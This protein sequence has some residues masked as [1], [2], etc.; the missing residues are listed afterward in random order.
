MS[1][2][3]SRICCDCGTRLTKIGRGGSPAAVGRP[4]PPAP[5]AEVRAS[6]AQSN[7]GHAEPDKGRISGTV[8]A[9]RPQCRPTSRGGSGG[10]PGSVLP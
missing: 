7:N 4:D 10:F 3:R 8:P 9:G 6:A 5:L 1:Q 2:K